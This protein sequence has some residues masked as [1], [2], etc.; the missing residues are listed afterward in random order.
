MLLTYNHEAYIGRAI[1]SVLAQ[2]A[3]FELI[4]TEDRSTDRTG[5]LVEAAAARDPA[6]I[7]LIR[8][9]VNLNTN[10]VTTRAIETAGGDYI[11]FL[12]GDDYWT[13]PRKLS[14]Q[15]AVLEARPELAMVFCDAEIVDAE[16]RTTAP[17]FLATAPAPAVGTYADIAASNYIAGPTPLIRR[18]AVAASPSWFEHAEF[19]DWPLYLLAA[20]QGDICLIPEVMAAYRVHGGGYWTG[21]DADVKAR[22]AIRF[23]NFLRRVA[24][25]RRR[26]AIDAAL[27]G[28]TARLLVEQVRGRRLPGAVQTLAGLAPL[29]LRGAPV[30]A[31]LDR[32]RSY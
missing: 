22:R 4:I 6:R 15:A 17:S 20:E 26:A 1:D 28:I 10:R 30:G 7:R 21:M 16:G 5:E 19:G 12:D 23:M 9:E 2:D 24:P 8:S 14:K 18:S 3:D 32:A 29:A 27:A 13:D 25:A 11:A 31:A